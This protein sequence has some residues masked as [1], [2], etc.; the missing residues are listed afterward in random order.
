MRAALQLQVQPGASRPNRGIPPGWD[1]GGEPPRTPPGPRRGRV[2][3][4][5]GPGSPVGGRMTSAAGWI[6]KARAESRA[7]S[8]PSRRRAAL[9]ACSPC[10]PSQ[11][12]PHQPAG[13]PADP[14][15]VA[16]ARLRP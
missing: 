12:A 9:G 5:I 1:K 2:R 13:L 16:A 7:Q 10:S 8:A 3:G 11:L 6:I 4:V 14:R 15:A